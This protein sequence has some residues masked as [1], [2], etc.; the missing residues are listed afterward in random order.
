[1][2]GWYSEHAAPLIKLTIIP[3]AKGSLG[4]AQY[5][6]DELTLYTTEQ[7]Q[8]MITVSL[9][10]RVAEEI[11]FKKITTGASDDLKKCTQI[12]SAM[13]TEYGMSSLLGT[14]NYSIDQMGEKSYSESTN[15]LIDEEVSRII[16]RSYVDCKKILED[17]KEFIEKLAER[18]LQNEVLNLPDI[19][20]IMGPRPFP[21]KES[22]QEY[23]R[24]L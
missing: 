21:M 4:F 22:V 14:L 15:R 6:P 11:F 17:K 2:A 12:A 10:G 16:N 9:G 18:L 3:R 19:V 20:E 5:L 8:D 1:M 23:L 7:L 24:E 13:I